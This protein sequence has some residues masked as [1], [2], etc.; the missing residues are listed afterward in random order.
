MNNNRASY[1]LIYYISKTKARKNGQVPVYL[2]IYIDGQKTSFQIRRHI[3][4]ELWD[5][6]K[7]KMKKARKARS[8]RAPQTNARII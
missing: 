8:N 7:S 2:Q 6:V 1:S 5:N 4:P 3:L